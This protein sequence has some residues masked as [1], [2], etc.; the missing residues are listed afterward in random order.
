MAEK[1]AKKAI[2]EKTR[3]KTPLKTPERILSLLARNKNM[4]VTELMQQ[5]DKSESAVWRAIQKLQKE[6]YLKR[7]GP[8]KGGY[9]K[10]MKKD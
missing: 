9:W 1:L 7:V 2:L 3:E 8:D 5:I 10:V 6:G 4:T